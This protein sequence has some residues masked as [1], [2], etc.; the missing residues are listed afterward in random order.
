MRNARLM[1]Q[2]QERENANA[3]RF[4]EAGVGPV[5]KTYS[6]DPTKLQARNVSKKA[7][8]S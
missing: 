6:Y 1:S 5:Q 7:K 8:G 3:T 2:M 4:K